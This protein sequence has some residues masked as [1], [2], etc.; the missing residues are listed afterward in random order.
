M[1][2]LKLIALLLIAFASF[3]SVNAQIASAEKKDSAEKATINNSEKKVREVSHD[4]I[5]YYVID[6]IWHT[7]FK[8]KLVLRQAP[9]GAR[10]SFLPKN[11]KIVTMGGKKYYKSNGIF[12]KKI[13]GGLYEVARP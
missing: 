10:V 1:N 13:K 7:K 8:N 5:K 11:G 9:K 12:Y 3:T 2:K 4:G 6:G